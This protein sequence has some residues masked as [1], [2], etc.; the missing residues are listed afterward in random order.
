VKVEGSIPSWSIVVKC[1]VGQVVRHFLL[2]EKIVGSNPIQD[3]RMQS[4]KELCAQVVQY[5]VNE[6][7]EVFQ[8]VQIPGSSSC[9]ADIVARKDSILWAI[10]CKLAMNLEVIG[11]AYGWAGQAHRVSVAVPVGLS[12][13]EARKKTRK[14]RDAFSNRESEKMWIGRTVCT[15][16]EIGVIE[17]PREPLNAVK[18]SVEAKT[19]Q[20]IS[21]KLGKA[22]R[23]EHKT[24]VAAGGNRGGHWTPFKAT[25]EAVRKF[26]ADKPGEDIVKI[27]SKIEHHYSSVN[28]GK[29][30][31]TKLIE[32]GK[33]PG[34]KIERVG[35]TI[36]VHPTK[37]LA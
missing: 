22:L 31:L 20:K 29:Y 32:E 14:Q 34:L 16:L 11:Q 30:A 25:C 23:E 4:E 28:S 13:I 33:V 5:L 2:T 1:P 8:E 36:K 24:A 19:R 26:V 7:W 15:K 6:G 9:V 27:L 35:K 3:T 10:E 21:S 37:L 17:V 18:V 12:M